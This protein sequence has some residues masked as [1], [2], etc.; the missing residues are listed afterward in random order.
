MV[1]Y[2]EKGKAYG[3]GPVLLEVFRISPQALVPP[4]TP[5]LKR[6]QINP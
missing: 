5:L 3:I 6:G 1:S 2:M 4:D